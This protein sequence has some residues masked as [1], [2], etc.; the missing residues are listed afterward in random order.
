MIKCCSR[1]ALPPGSD[2]ALQQRERVAPSLPTEIIIH[3]SEHVKRFGPKNSSHTKKL[4]AICLVCRA[5]Y[6]ALV[7]VLY[8]SP[9][10]D[11]SRFQ[12]FVETICSPV[13]VHASKNGLADVIHTIDL[14]S[15]CANPGKFTTVRLVSRVRQNLHVFM[16]S[17]LMSFS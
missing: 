8:N 9:H 10:R 16:A 2:M 11:Q 5:W 3:I 13:N 4:R 15:L 14:R 17:H 6:A 1:H 12:R 7:R